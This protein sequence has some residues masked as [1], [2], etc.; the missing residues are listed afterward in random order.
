MTLSDE[1]FY[2]YTVSHQ[3]TMLC[4][5]SFQ[6]SQELIGDITGDGIIGSADILELISAYGCLI[7]C[8]IDFTSNGTTDVN[9]LLFLL[10]NFGESC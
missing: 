4:E 7:D 3:G 10:I 9:D 1:G 2:K 5:S 6:I 8:S